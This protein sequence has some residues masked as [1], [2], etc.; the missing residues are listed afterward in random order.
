M[1]AGVGSVG[2]GCIPDIVKKK[3]ENIKVKNKSP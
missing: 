1:L 2:D 3:I